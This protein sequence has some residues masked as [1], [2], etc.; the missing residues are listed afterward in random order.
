ML[1]WIVF[2]FKPASVGCITSS[3]KHILSQIS[4]GKYLMLKIQQPYLNFRMYIYLKDGKMILSDL[5]QS[6][7]VHQNC[8]IELWYIKVLGHMFK[9]VLPE[10]SAACV[11]SHHLQCEAKSGK[12]KSLWSTAQKHALNPNENGSISINHLKYEWSAAN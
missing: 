8:V 10:S 5:L 6:G 3:Y 7:A 9:N 11:L 1:F 12:W 4:R 2:F